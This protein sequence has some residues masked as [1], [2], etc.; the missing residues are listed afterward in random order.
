MTVG[1]KESQLPPII[2]KKTTQSPKLSVYVGMTMY[3]IVSSVCKKHFRWR[4][5]QLEDDFDLMWADH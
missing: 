5:D 1:K 4:V 2:S 3:P